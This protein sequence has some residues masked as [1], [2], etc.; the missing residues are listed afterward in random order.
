M[1]QV[2]PVAHRYRLAAGDAFRGRNC[3]RKVCEKGSHIAAARYG[4]HVSAAACDLSF[5]TPRRAAAEI[6]RRHVANG[7]AVNCKWPGS[8][9]TGFAN[10]I[11]SAAEEGHEEAPA[12]HLPVGV[13]RCRAAA[14]VVCDGCRNGTEADVL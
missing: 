10:F 2:T 13:P 1:R 7:H 8:E 3:D 6:R 5:C 12:D 11:V 9:E 14:G 4:Q